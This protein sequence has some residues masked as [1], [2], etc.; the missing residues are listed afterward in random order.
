VFRFLFF[1]FRAA[2]RDERARNEGTERT[3]QSSMVEV[4]SRAS[5]L[6]RQ[7]R[8][9]EQPSDGS[10]AVL[11]S[12]ARTATGSLGTSLK[13]KKNQQVTHVYNEHGNDSVSG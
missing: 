3:L 2:W 12:I 11:Y 4:A 9:R 6:E 1:F 5:A 8:L 7:S 10:P 13:N